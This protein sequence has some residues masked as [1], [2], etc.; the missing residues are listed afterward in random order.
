MQINSKCHFN[1][2]FLLHFKQRLSKQIAPY[3]IYIVTGPSK[4]LCLVCLQ[5]NNLIQI[6]LKHNISTEKK[7]DIILSHEEKSVPCGK[8]YRGGEENIY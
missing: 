2:K 4:P 7:K 3:N 6:I 5:H 1:L 8:I